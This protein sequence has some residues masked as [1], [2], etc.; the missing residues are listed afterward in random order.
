MLSTRQQNTA[1]AAA[2]AA[3]CTSPEQTRNT[4]LCTE[5]DCISPEEKCI[6]LYMKNTLKKYI[7]YY[8]KD[9]QRRTL[10]RYFPAG[11]CCRIFDSSYLQPYE[12]NEVWKHRRLQGIQPRSFPYGEDDDY[13]N[14]DDDD[15]LGVV[16]HQF[17]KTIEEQCKQTFYRTAP[18]CCG[19]VLDIDPALAFATDYT[20][21]STHSILPFIKGK[22][23]T[24]TVV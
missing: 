19:W 5:A 20:K 6:Q 9:D 18:C 11:H 7:Y 1:A 10:L 17:R 13:S 3:D 4:Q 8:K 21:A 24:K 15:E 2:A 23:G 22:L 16:V 12:R 14:G